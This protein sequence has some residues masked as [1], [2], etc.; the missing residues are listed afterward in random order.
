MGSA[1]LTTVRYN[2]ASCSVEGCESN[3]ISRGW[4]KLHYSRVL[5][6]GDTGEAVRRRVHNYK[7]EVCNVDGR[8]E[9]LLRYLRGPT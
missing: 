8:G 7:R 3:A 5:S 2:G 4:C 9:S 6:T 1:D